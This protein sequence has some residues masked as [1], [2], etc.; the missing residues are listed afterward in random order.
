MLIYTSDDDEDPFEGFT[1]GE[2]AA[3]EQLVENLS[4]LPFSYH[5]YTCTASRTKYSGSVL[6]GET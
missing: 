3:G 4:D 5:A 1:E 2:V 6:V